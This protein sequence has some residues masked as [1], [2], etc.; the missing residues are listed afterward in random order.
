MQSVLQLYD[1]ITEELLGEVFPV[2]YVPSCYKRDE[3]KFR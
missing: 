2:W 1:K 3:S